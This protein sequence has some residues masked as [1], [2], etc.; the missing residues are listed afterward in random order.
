[1]LK[2]NKMHYIVF[3]I[4]INIKNYVEF[5]DICIICYLFVRMAESHLFPPVGFTLRTISF[6]HVYQDNNLL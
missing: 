5:K 4:N 2:I 6:E 3:Q 1:M